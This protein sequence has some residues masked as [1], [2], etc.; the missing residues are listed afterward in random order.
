MIVHIYV[1]DV[2]FYRISSKMLEHF[3]QQRKDEFELIMVKDVT[4]F[5]NFQVKKMNGFTFDSQSINVGSSST[6]LL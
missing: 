6:Q 4:Y 5:P 3:S 1:E 2:G